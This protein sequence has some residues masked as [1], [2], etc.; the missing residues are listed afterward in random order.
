M[1]CVK[2]FKFCSRRK[3]N[4]DCRKG[5]GERVIKEVFRE[6]IKSACKVG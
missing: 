1:Y 4:S 2:K 5:G 3:V 6:G